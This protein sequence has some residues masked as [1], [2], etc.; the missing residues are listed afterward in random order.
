MT[1]YGKKIFKLLRRPWRVF[2]L[3]RIRFF[4]WFGDSTLNDGERFDPIIHRRFG[5]TETSS[6]ARYRFAQSVIGATGEILDIACGT[7]Y[8]TLLLADNCQR[9]SGVDTEAAALDFARRH[10]QRSAKINFYQGTVAD[11][12]ITADVIVCLETLEHL[13]EDLE[14]AVNGLLEHCRE[15]LIVSVPYQ[16]E[17]GHNKHHRKFRLSEADFR[18]L[19]RSGRLNFYYQSPDGR[20]SPDKYPETETLLLVW[21]RIRPAKEPVTP[22]PKISVVIPNWNGERFLDTCL[23]SLQSQSYQDFELIIVDN[24]S[25][26][27]SLSI[28]NHLYPDAQIIRNEDNLG[29][30]RAVNQGWERAAGLYVFLLNNDTE[31]TPDCLEK[32]NDFLDRQPQAAVAAPKMLYFADRRLINDAGDRLSIYG[33]ASKRGQGE[34]DR[35]QYEVI[36]RIFGACAGGAIYRKE[37]LERLQGFAANFF[38]YLEDVD[39]SFRANLIGYQTYF[40]PAARLYHVDGGTSRQRQNQTYF[41]MVRNGLYLIFRNYPLALLIPLLPCLLL[42]QLRN[43]FS[44]RRHH[45]RAE[46]VQAYREFW[47]A[48]PRLI[49]ERRTIQ[50]ARL[51]SAYEI[52]KLLD[53]KYPF[54]IKRHIYGLF[55]HHR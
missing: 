51:I 12:R 8:G 15:K 9:I 16:E 52:W 47:Q 2:H 14:T 25:Q 30:S 29:F 7:G 38:A 5:V 45:Y 40:V 19:E 54:P 55:F 53:K 13:D 44:S 28:V 26:D 35:G 4:H 33:L 1:S 6:L 22:A 27:D 37:V 10:Y 24:G 23:A 39:L 43:F 3:A 42:G 31:L 36:E 17:P 46:L 18:F 41:L 21:E 11:N 34:I 20:I 32:L 48:L 49:E 50:A